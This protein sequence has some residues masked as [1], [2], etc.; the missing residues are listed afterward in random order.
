MVGTILSLQN[1]AYGK[2]GATLEEII[3]ACKGANA[4]D[5]SI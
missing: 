2:P 3:E 5:V 1:V 4:H